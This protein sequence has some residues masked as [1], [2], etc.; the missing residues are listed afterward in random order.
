MVYS[1]KAR[2]IGIA[3]VRPTS[4]SRRLNWRDWDLD[5]VTSVA[6][7]FSDPA[8]DLMSKIALLLAIRHVTEVEKALRSEGFD[9]SILAFR[10]RELGDAT[11]EAFLDLLFSSVISVCL[12]DDSTE[13]TSSMRYFLE[14]V[15]SASSKSVSEMVESNVRRRWPGK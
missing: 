10:T 15:A 3:S 5:H 1:R 8:H 11:L 2:A 6:R 9:Q 7:R 14:C 4:S 12:D 13:Y